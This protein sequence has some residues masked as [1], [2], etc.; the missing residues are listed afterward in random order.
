MARNAFR[1][2]GG[3][4]RAEKTDLTACFFS[5][6]STPFFLPEIAGLFLGEG[7]TTK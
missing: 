4:F 3:R 5:G 2:A 6:K 1:R 7:V